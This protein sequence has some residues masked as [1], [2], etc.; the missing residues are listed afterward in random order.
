MPQAGPTV[1]DI[2]A[3]VGPPVLHVGSGGP[4][5]THA[6][7]DIS[8]LD[9][10]DPATVAPDNLL[11]AVAVDPEGGHAVA[12]VDRASRAGA[13]GVVVKADGPLPPRVVEPAA[14][15][16]LPLLTVPP[17]M[18]WGRLYSLLRT[19]LSGLA[20]GG[21][22]RAGGG[23]V[24]V[25]DLFSF[26]DAVAAAV[27][28]PVTIE[29]P[30]WRVVAYS[31]LDQPVDE[32]RRETILGR[33]PPAAWLERIETAGV[34]RALRSGEEVVRFAHAGLQPRL[35]A[36]I[37][38]GDELLG[39]IWVLEG[40]GPLGAQ[41]VQEL[42]RAAQ[43]AGIHLLAHRSGE[44]LERRRRAALVRDLLEGRASGSEGL[45]PP[46]H[47]LVACA[48]RVAPEAREADVNPQ[49]LLGIV[50]LFAETVSARAECAA[51]DG[52]IWALVP[53]APGR[54]RE[55][56]L[57]MAQ[58]TV[59][60]AQRVLGVPLHGGIGAA[61]AQTA[62]VPASRDAALRALAVL[63]RRAPR[64]EAVAHIDDVREHAALLELLEGIAAR[65]DLAGTKVGRLATLDA[66]RGTCYVE[67]L[68]GW[69]D[70]HGD[71][72]RAAEAAGVHPNTF[73]YR[74]R[75]LA[76]IAGL[77]LEDPEER[78]V[79]ALQLRALEFRST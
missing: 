4:G 32:A 20:V 72:V 61:A 39:S 31:N 70:A 15:A 52:R 60:R 21:D 62:D 47:E 11:L 57:D 44:D 74:L 41:A 64:T 26:A 54:G 8:I 6:V 48:F 36:P 10:S 56:A 58:R 7:A 19:A 38:V 49:R 65:P 67:T 12:L 79:A 71:A 59:D 22:D 9:H 34:L 14:A 51:L 75:R 76:E 27:G 5:L 35:I 37:R 30:Q 16:G 66:Q 53:A 40:S 17:E 78:L 68:R 28:A 1:G 33:T 46:G 24:S 3:A 45:P 23:G 2:V 55:R 25:G 69:L 50:G 77:D 18:A 13:A 43:R 42:T 63:A 29:D 73:R